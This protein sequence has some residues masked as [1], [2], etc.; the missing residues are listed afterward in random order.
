MIKSFFLNI[1]QRRHFWRHV[2]FGEVAE[3][4]MSR[5]LRLTAI[6]LGSGFASVFLY[7]EGYSLIFIMGMWAAYYAMGA[8]LSPL[9]GYFAARFSAKYG[10][11][12]SNILYIPAM[13][14]LG[15]VPEYGLPMVITSLVFMGISSVLY[16][17]CYYVEFSRIK[18]SDNAGKELGFMNVLEKITIAIS[19]IIGGFIALTFGA[20]VTMWAAG[21]LFALAALPLLRT[22]DQVE[23]RQRIVIRGFPWRMAISSIMSRSAIGFDIVA[24]GTVWGLFIALVMFPTA[25]EGVYVLLGGLASVTIVVAIVASYTFGKL[26]DKKQ[27]GMLLKVAVGS[28]SLIHATRAFITTVPGLIGVNITN[29]AATTAQNMSFLRGMFD[30][31]D[32]SGHRVMYLVCIEIMSCLGAA[33]ACLVFMLCASLIGESDGFRVFYL[34]TAVVVLGVASARFR[35]YRP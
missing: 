18:S 35:L 33:I 20:Q 2:S 30:T 13:V 17:I 11:L 23:K 29:E 25:G 34:I 14:A 31:A 15:F 5:T 4:Y 22:P 16:T 28:N 26:I 19:P 3:L 27:G 32:L 12:F 6:Y 21:T 7:K 1:L 10:I 9:L 24:T 8:V